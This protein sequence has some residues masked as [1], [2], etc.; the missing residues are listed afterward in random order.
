MKIINIVIILIAKVIAFILNLL[1]K[2]AGTVPGRIA[3]KLNKNIRDFIKTDAKIIVVT[4]TNGKT[5]TTNMI[6]EILQRNNKKVVCN[7]GGNNIGWGITTTLIKNANITG[8]IKADYILLETDE[9]WVPVIYA[10]KNLKI[11]TLIVLN[12]F[13]DQL[14]RTG[15]IEMLVSKLE[16]FIKKNNC[17]LILNGND[18]NVVR[19]GLVN[20][21]NYY[22]GIGKIESSYKNTDT[23]TEGSL[24]PKCKKPLKYKYY[25]YSHIGEYKC[26]DCDFGN[27]K[28]D[29]KV[30]KIDNNKFYIKKEEYITNNK[31]IYNIYNL[32]SI[33]TLSN[34]YDIDKNIVKQVFK[35]YEDKNGRYQKF[36][37]NNRE[38]IL[39]LGK[40]PVGFNVIIRNIKNDSSNKDLLIILNDNEND[41]RDVSWIWGIDFTNI[42]GFERIICSGTRAYDMAITIKCNNYNPKKI[43]VEHDIAKAIE[44]LLE[45]KNKKYIISNYSP[46][47]KAKNILKHLEKGEK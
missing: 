3:L 6:Y 44:H 8:K 29:T 5:T 45:T 17:K 46:L 9:H 23:K 38:C 24:C 43:I 18:P 26:S 42:N 40:N 16:S 27:I 10:K 28:L 2:K 12:F 15:E 4:G 22:Y 21:E 39:N 32:L 41:G 33:I 1:G 34:I 11:D 37:I 25:Q 7:I 19:L 31:N 30:S 13:A 47:P 36:L 35:N 14:D 20:K